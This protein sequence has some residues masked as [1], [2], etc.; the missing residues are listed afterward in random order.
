MRRKEGRTRKEVM[1]RKNEASDEEK[2]REARHYVERQEF[3]NNQ[4]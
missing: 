2:G 3:G 4:S 1:R